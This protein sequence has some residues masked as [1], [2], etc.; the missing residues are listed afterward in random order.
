MA[1]A[2]T[3]PFSQQRQS[4]RPS[5]VSSSVITVQRTASLSS[6]AG[7]HSAVSG[8][9]PQSPPGA[10][11]PTASK[12]SR[13]LSPDSRRQASAVNSRPNSFGVITEGVGNLN[14]WSE[15]TVSSKSSATHDR[16]NS[17][18]RRLSGSLGS[19]GS[20]TTSQSPPTNRNVSTKSRLSPEENPKRAAV[21]VTS[22]L[23]AASHPHTI[24]LS[25]PPQ[26]LDSSD[27]SSATA[28]ATP[29]TADWLTTSA[30]VSGSK[31][32]FR[33]DWNTTGSLPRQ[34]PYIQQFITAPSS[35]EVL[36]SPPTR[37][38]HF[39]SGRSS[40]PHEDFGSLGVLQ[41]VQRTEARS[42]YT[43]REQVPRRRLSRNREEVGKSSIATEDESSASSVQ[44]LREWRRKVPSQK[45]MLSRA[46]QKAN[47]AVLLDNAQNFEGAMDAYGDACDLL[48]QVMVR[49]S[50]DE[51]RKKLEAIVYALI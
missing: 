24:I 11:L 37:S 23:P 14:R 20:F 31:D 26:A 6:R 49:T 8:R 13:T 39:G 51:D 12:A 50:G 35:L 19:L 45:A 29:A 30:R 15:S 33:E 42:K 4:S 28:A 25:S 27:S 16:R 32:L 17:F 18:A 34:E 2:I 5:S 1:S 3:K 41:S 38:K 10:R 44:S 9:R 7:A 36:E 22:A 48:Q 47:H 40:Q 46:L 43:G 21:Q